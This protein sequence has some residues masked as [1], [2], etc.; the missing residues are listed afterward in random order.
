MTEDG[1]TY[2]PHEHA[3]T[4]DPDTSHQAAWSVVDATEMQQRVYA[5]FVRHP[6]GLTD[7]Q[8]VAIYA[9]HYPSDWKSLE[10]KASPRKR[11]SDLTNLGVIIDSGEKRPLQ[12]KRLGIV[13]K[14]AKYVT[15]REEAGCDAR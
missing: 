13:W 12:S 15:P 2:D 11:R 3:R 14:L 7:E 8:L 10:S 6:D 9:R 4:D 1:F 5:I